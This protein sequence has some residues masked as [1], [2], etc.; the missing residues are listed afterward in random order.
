MSVPFMVPILT[1]P[2]CLQMV[3]IPSFPNCSCACLNIAVACQLFSYHAKL[4]LHAYS[5]DELINYELLLVL[6]GN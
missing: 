4:T 3:Y 1:N 6:R 2:K 5:F